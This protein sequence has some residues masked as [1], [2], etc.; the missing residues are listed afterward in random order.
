MTL[1]STLFIVWIRWGFT[2]KV[3]RLLIGRIGR[4]RIQLRMNL[5]VPV[6]M[7][8]CLRRVRRLIILVVLRRW[9]VS[10]GFVVRT[11]GLMLVIILRSRRR[12]VTLI[13]FVVIRIVGWLGL[14]LVTVVLG[15]V[16]WRCGRLF[17]TLMGRGRW[18][19]RKI[20]CR[21]RR[22]RNGGGRNVTGLIRLVTL[23]EG[24]WCFH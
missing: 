13:T 7:I 16:I 8:R 12:R 10:R 2:R 11:R 18:V 15:R 21:C 24:G 5:S 17:V 9:W 23:I 1:V 14:V 4:R 20:C 6:R 19:R 22:I 3:L